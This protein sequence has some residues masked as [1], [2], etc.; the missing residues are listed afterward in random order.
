M[1]KPYCSDL[2]PFPSL[3]QSIGDFP[4]SR[5]LD[6]LL[7][8]GS[9]FSLHP[10]FRSPDDF[11]S[12]SGGLQDLPISNIVTITSVIVVGYILRNLYK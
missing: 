3:A 12:F 11:Y 9:D 10:S 6:C 4:A 7:R 1:G 8:H 2:D 5:Q